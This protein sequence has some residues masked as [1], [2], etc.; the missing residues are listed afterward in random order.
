MD[1]NSKNDVV[2]AL[3]LYSDST[4]LSGKGNVSGW[5]VIMSLANIPLKNRRKHGGYRL[6]GLLPEAHKDMD[7][8]TKVDIFNKCLEVILNPLKELSHNGLNYNGFTLFPFLYAY[9]H[10]Y[11]EGCKVIFFQHFSYFNFTNKCTK[12]IS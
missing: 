9:V 2:L 11:P 8:T 4:L 3:I 5:P 7:S 12:N 10:D 6:M 1:N